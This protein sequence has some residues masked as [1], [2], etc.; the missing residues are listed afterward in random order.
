MAYILVMAGVWFLLELESWG[1]FLY[2]RGIILDYLFEVVSAFGTVG[3]STGVTPKLSP[4]SKIVLVIVMIIG[5]TGP[6]VW[7]AVLT[8]KRQRSFY[9][10]EEEVLIG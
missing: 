2:E 4:W 1:I 10:A 9:Y 8:E 5:R 3:L 6:L 7:A